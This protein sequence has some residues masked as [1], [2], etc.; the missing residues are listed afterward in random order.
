MKRQ[1]RQ[2]VFET[3]SSSTHAM[4][5]QTAPNVLYGIY[6][7]KSDEEIDKY[8]EQDDVKNGWRCKILHK[9][10]L[11]AI[12]KFHGDEFGWE[13]RTYTSDNYEAKASYL[14]TLMSELLSYEEFDEAVKRF[15]KWFEEEGVT[16][17]FQEY[18]RSDYS[19]LDECVYLPS[20]VKLIPG[21]DDEEDK[22]F[23]VDHADDAEDFLLYVISR[24]NNLFN[25]LFGDSF[26]KT[27]ND[28]IECDISLCSEDEH[29]QFDCTHKKFYKGN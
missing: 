5:V 23:Y 18:E 27:G 22:W 14:W 20:H 4:A 28:N 15:T 1:V 16:P 13:V 9:S 7:N 26:I 2:G 10:D 8:N 19:Y 6:T 29:W 17:E 25:Y 24:K 12:I 3:N 21:D 11:P